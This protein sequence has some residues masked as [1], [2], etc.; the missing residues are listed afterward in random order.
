MLAKS[1]PRAIIPAMPILDISRTLTASL[2]VWPGDPPFAM[3]MLASR[4]A[5]AA[6]NLSALALSAHTGAHVDAPRHFADDAPTVAT[7]DLMPFWG[8]AQVVTVDRA[9][10]P[11][12]PADFSRVDLRRAPRLLV[13][14]A[15]SLV[16]PELFPAAYVF[17]S[18]ELADHLGRFGICLYGTD[19]PSVDPVES[20]DLP[21]H[22]A[23]LR[24]GIAILEGLN[25]AHVADG[26]YELVALPLK[27]AEGD[28]SPVRAALRTI[29]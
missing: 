5:G 29:D 26:L 27:I 6:V 2:A 7:L 14:S 15:A 21:S 22:L 9:A 17:P 10:G 16:A 4:R 3:Q 8:P 25:L 24:N 19:T 23:L 1:A 13:R 28:G 12:T 18:P 11:L 20:A